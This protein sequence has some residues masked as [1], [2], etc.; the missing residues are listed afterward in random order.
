M[1][2][3]S[4]LS[5]RPPLHLTCGVPGTQARLRKPRKCDPKSRSGCGPGRPVPARVWQR[6]PSQVSKS[7]RYSRARAR[8][9]MA[10]CGFGRR[11]RCRRRVRRSRT[12]AC[13][14]RAWTRY[15]TCLK[16]I[17]SKRACVRARWR[18]RVRSCERFDVLGYDSNGYS[19]GSHCTAVQGA[20]NVNGDR[21]SQKLWEDGEKRRA[22]RA[23]VSERSSVLY[24]VLPAA[25]ARSGGRHQSH[26]PSSAPSI[27]RSSTH[28]RS[29]LA[30][31][32]QR[33]PHHFGRVCAGSVGLSLADGW[34]P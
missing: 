9:A 3:C 26:S 15:R 18:L 32:G 21:I 22:R 1:W 33:P 11:C 23:R 34:S 20:Q 31:L 4:L 25:E 14:A 17:A 7:A 30:A 2:Q 28:A 6:R 10:P 12:R 24:I 29:G 8:G 13:G 5:A 16:P 27:L 19:R